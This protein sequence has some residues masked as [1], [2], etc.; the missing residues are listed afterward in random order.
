LKDSMKPMIFDTHAHYDDR[1]F[2]E[3]QEAVINQ[4]N[5]SGV[6]RVVNIAADVHSVESTYLLAHKYPFVYGALGVHPSE[7]M[8]LLEKDMARIA[9]LALE[10]RQNNQNKIVAIGEIGLDYHEED[11]PK[12]KQIEWFERQLD[13]AKQLDLPVVIHSRD[14]AEDTYRILKNNLVKENAGIIHCYSYSKE[15]AKQFLDLGYYIG[16]GGVV[17]FKNGRVAKE[18]VSYLPEDRLLLETDSPYIAPEPLRGSRNWSANL[19]YVAEKMAELR[20]TTTEN[21]IQKTWENAN[22]LY[23]IKEQD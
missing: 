10:D 13:L 11:V 12:E 19:I 15:M 17:T 1:R 9:N 14:A 21:I 16:L 18:V 8:D 4:L 23:R 5:K 6:G 7:T 3:D 22:R 20:Q 2:E